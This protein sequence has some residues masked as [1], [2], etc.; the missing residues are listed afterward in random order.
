MPALNDL[1]RE[2]Q[3]SGSSLSYGGWLERELREAREAAKVAQ[4]QLNA[5]INVQ[6]ALADRRAS[7]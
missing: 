1:I 4:E 7:R 6:E 3:S 5:V 2:W